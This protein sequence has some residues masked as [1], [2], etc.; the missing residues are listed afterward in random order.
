MLTETKIGNYICGASH[1]RSLLG[2][3]RI[4]TSRIL[5]AAVLDK[6]PS[7]FK[8]PGCFARVC[9]VTHCWFLTIPSPATQCLS[10]YLRS[11][12][13][14]VGHHP[15]NFSRP[16]TPCLLE[17]QIG[18]RPHMALSHISSRE[19][20]GCS[21]LSPVTLPWFVAI[22]GTASLRWCNHGSNQRNVPPGF[23]SRL[24][25]WPSFLNGWI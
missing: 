10:R 23:S 16:F 12:A 4:K 8:G 21:R 18:R 20:L 1:A 5:H 6:N 15:S 11:L 13:T 25:P 14:L 9:N 7:L 22:S 17:D 19:P 24:W 2:I 3:T